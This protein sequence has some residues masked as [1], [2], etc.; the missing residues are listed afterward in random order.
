MIQEAI[1]ILGR[2]SVL[3]S[4]MIVAT[5]IAET[6]ARTQTFQALFTGEPWFHIPDWLALCSLVWLTVSFVRWVRSA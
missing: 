4:A 5:S 1:R 2:L 6:I 3:A